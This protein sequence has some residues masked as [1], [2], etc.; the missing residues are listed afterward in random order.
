MTA[1]RNLYLALGMTTI[2]NESL[3]LGLLNFV[4]T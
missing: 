3:E 2:N 4:K 1:A